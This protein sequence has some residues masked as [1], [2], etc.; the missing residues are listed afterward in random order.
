M[1]PVRQRESQ[2][3][4]IS[5]GYPI[6]GTA[7]RTQPPFLKTW[8]KTM[9]T[10]KARLRQSLGEKQRH[11]RTLRLEALEDRRVLATFMVTNLSDGPVTGPGDLPGSLRQAV[12]DC[13]HNAGADD[14]MIQSGLTGTITLTEGELRI[15][16][17]V[18]VTGLGRD[19]TTIDA[20][21]ASRAMNIDDGLS[22]NVLNVELR[23]LSITGGSVSGHGGGIFSQENLV[24]RDS[25][26][27]QNEVFSGDGGGIYNQWGDLTLM[28]S[29]VHDNATR[30]SEGEG[31]GLFTRDGDLFVIDSE[32]LQNRT[33][34]SQAE[35]G[36]I[37][38]RAGNL[39]ITNSTIS[40]NATL[41]QGSDGGG[42]FARDGMFTVTD[43]VISD[44]YTVGG[45]AA[46]APGGGI[47][48]YSQLTMTNT[49]MSGNHTLGRGGRGGAIFASGVLMNIT[50]STIE[51][52]YTQGDVGHGGAVYSRNGTTHFYMS[53]VSGNS[54]VG[55]PA[56]GGGIFSQD[57]ILTVTDSTLTDNSTAG[58]GSKGGAIMNDTNP[59]TIERSLIADNRTT[60]GS[61]SG[62][63]IY[64]R[65]GNVT[66]VDTTISGNATLGTSDS[67][68]GGI[69]LNTNLVGSQTALISNST[70][71]GNS[72]N[73]F[74]GGVFNIDGVTI[75]RHSTVTAN[76]AQSG[77]GSGVFSYGN[78]AART[79][80]ASTIVAGNVNS[81][82]DFAR[83]FGTPTNT[84]VSNG[85]NLLGTGNALPAF[86]NNDQ[87]HVADPLLGPLADNGG[88]TL[89]HELL[90]GSPAIDAGDPAAMAG[91]GNVPEF[92]QRGA[93]FD[94]VAAA[95]ID[96]GSFEVQQ[97]I[98]GDFNDDGFYD[99]LDI[100]ALTAEIAAM[101]N[102]PEFDLT[103]D[104]FV[105]LEDL[106]AWLVEGGANNPAQTGGNPFLLGDANLDGFVDGL[107]FIEWN[108]HRF[109]TDSAWCHGDFN[110]DG[111][112]DG[113]DFILWNGN[114]FQSSGNASI[115]NPLPELPNEDEPPIRRL[116][117]D[118]ATIVANGSNLVP[119]SPALAPHKID[120]LLAGGHR[121]RSGAT[122]A[123]GV[124]SLAGKVAW[125]NDAWELVADRSAI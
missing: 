119:S 124:V 36:G 84:F 58:V 65:H 20:N 94:R 4:R 120:L 28:G 35:G 60:G 113:L 107:D 12:Y 25:E 95:R 32:V 47:F 34:G 24:V 82:I 103:A 102:R 90:L 64:A 23:D 62:G 5:G 68:G 26:I 30:S 73:R 123:P 75:I 50:D 67:Y 51:N 118:A 121:V 69:A 45:S 66:V 41:G 11:R 88:P 49:T 117:T 81:D 39:T 16:D 85:Y 97:T 100:N 76:S 83:L 1:K 122:S 9:K 44:N 15:T 22:G 3:K 115:T 7:L 29:T 46:S 112:I 110:A 106:D 57:G 13:N 55:S 111:F 78:S 116:M 70:I 42:I 114:R 52:N 93:P 18:I 71:S 72:T 91:M 109:T 63:G 74:G 19:Q 27:F 38:A 92:D 104:G 43:S 54:T 89:T 6:H 98:D 125:D 101:T 80:L 31:G 87:T 48:T 59:M 10:R 8:G 96:I 37:L 61:A 99:C 14:I 21:S 77:R 53:T 56:Q 2:R 17:D 79:E 40:G 108:D 86:N 33:H 105:N